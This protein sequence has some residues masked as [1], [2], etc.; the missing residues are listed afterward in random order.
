M[1]GL[2]LALFLLSATALAEE[3][4]QR[5][6]LSGQVFLDGD[7]FEEFHSNDADSS[8][9]EGMVR[10]ARVQ[11]DYDFPRGWLGKLQIDGELESLDGDGDDVDVGS[12]YLRYTHWEV[13]DITLGRMK[14]PLG[15]ER[16]TPVNGLRTIE[17]SMM[18]RAFTPSKS[19][20]LHL[21]KANSEHRWALAAVVEDDQDDRYDEDPPLALTG[22]YTFVP[23]DEDNRKFQLGG[24]ASARDWNDNLYQVRSSAEIGSAD[25]VVRS[26]LFVA[27]MQYTGGLEAVWR[28]DRLL[29]MAEYMATRVEETDG[30]DWDYSGWY[31]TASYLITGEKQRLRRGD[32][33][34]VQ[35][36]REGGAW[37]L[38]ARYSDLDV[39]DEGLGSVA[40]V[41]T[42]GVNFYY[43]RKVRVMLN[44]V[45]ADIAGDTR[46][47]E[48]DGFAASAR[49]QVRF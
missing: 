31:V 19:W 46:H 26:A 7:Y 13:A 41:S 15:F 18:T 29:L 22:R 12:A 6:Q 28:D 27:D 35:P 24:S 25:N 44:L 21:F 2:I 38:V 23:Y 4:K 11:V 34:R 14:E 48:T 47:L 33:K 32:L 40:S 45:Y 16:N 17:G 43:S 30:A 39:R 10:L 20:G 1:R 8:N 5:L 3:E 37:E 49:L 42:L 9:W 36:G